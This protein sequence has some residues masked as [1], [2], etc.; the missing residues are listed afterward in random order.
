MVHEM[1]RI[2]ILTGGGDASG[3]NAVIRA[4]TLAAVQADVEVVG[5]RNGF[6]GLVESNF[7]RLDPERVHRIHR[8]GGS[9]LGCDNIFRG[10]AADFA[11]GVRRAALE[12]LVVVGGDGSL[13]QAFVF[14]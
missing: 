14:A 6:R 11:D 3:L 4:T 13:T 2:G 8:R 12:G 7:M 10:D 1:K 5:I 9:I